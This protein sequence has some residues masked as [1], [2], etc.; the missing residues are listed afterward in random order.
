MTLGWQPALREHLNLLKL[1]PGFVSPQSG[2]VVE[3]AK[4][5]IKLSFKVISEHPTEQLSKRKTMAPELLPT[6]SGLTNTHAHFCG[7]CVLVCVCYFFVNLA[8]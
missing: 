3:A 6:A 2:T 1:N 5:L 4:T 8:E 7:M